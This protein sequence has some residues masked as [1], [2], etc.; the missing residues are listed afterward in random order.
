MQQSAAIRCIF[1][2]AEKRLPHVFNVAEQAVIETDITLTAKFLL[3]DEIGRRPSFPCAPHI[4][5][6]D[7]IVCIGT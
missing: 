1:R 3:Q 6:T 7:M 2:T 5:L 4:A